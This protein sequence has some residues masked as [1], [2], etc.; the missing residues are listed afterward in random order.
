LL[1]GIED[2]LRQRLDAV[3]VEDLCWPAGP[4]AAVTPRTTADFT[5]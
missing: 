1:A 3:T 5:I 4:G 2:E